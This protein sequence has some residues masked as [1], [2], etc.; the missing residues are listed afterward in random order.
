MRYVW[1]GLLAA[2]SI[3]LMAIVA[4]A[5]AQVVTT[6]DGHYYRLVPVKRPASATAPEM[7]NV[8]P[9]QATAS[10]APVSNCRLT[11]FL[12]GEYQPEYSTVCG[13]Q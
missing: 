7:V 11:S 2:A 4:P 8:I 6:P 3:G 10:V 1:V 13:P 9:E 12:N 5:S